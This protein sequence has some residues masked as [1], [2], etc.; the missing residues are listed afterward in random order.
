MNWLDVTLV[1]FLALSTLLGLS[2][3]LMKI[4]LPAIGLMIGI[5]AAGRY[6]DAVAH[7][8]FSSHSNAAYILSFVLIVIIFMTAAVILANI[9]HKTL[10]LIM[11]GWID[12][13][14]GAVLC[15]AIS[16]MFAGAI[17]ALLLKYS[18]AVPTIEDSAVAS[19]L[20][21]KFPFSLSSLPGDFKDVKG[22][23]HR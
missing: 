12:R 22:F 8:V 23:F 3:G 9:L 1:L 4:V 13:L 14:A 18:L 19:F 6:Y 7:R 16:T 10:S 2:R 21:D 5:I 20:V 15:L 11:L 17:L